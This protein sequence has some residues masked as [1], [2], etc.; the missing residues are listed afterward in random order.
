MSVQRLYQLLAAIAVITLIALVS[1]R[2]RSM[3]SVLSTMPVNLTITIWFVV[4]G[5]KTDAQG[6]ADLT[7]MQFW[8]MWPT[9]LFIVTCFLGF[10][11][12]W[13]MWRALGTGYAVWAVGIAIYRSIEWALHRT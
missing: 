3:A 11:R 10:R 13:S 1:E 5:N 6:A 2:S 12:E 8:G 4:S 9:M 7:R